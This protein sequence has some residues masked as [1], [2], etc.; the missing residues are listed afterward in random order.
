[1]NDEAKALP[2]RTIEI[3]G[4]EYTPVAARMKDFREKFP[5]EKGF[6]VITSI[7]KLNDNCVLMRCEIRDI[8]GLVLGTGHAMEFW[9]SSVLNQN[10]A[11]EVA[12]TSAIGRAL[13]ALGFH[14][15]E[16]AS[17]EEY[18][19]AIAEQKALLDKMAAEVKELIAAGNWAELCRIDREDSRW[20]E[21]WG[22]LG[23]KDRSAAKKCMEMRSKYRDDLNVM[24]NHGDADGFAQLCGELTREEAAEL[25]RVLTPEARTM[26]TEHMKEKD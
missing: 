8:T 18:D 19:R 17:Q 12:E 7:Q 2:T 16:Y 9:A 4:R 20:Q 25:Y 5:V 14:G 26:L 10:S 6:S 15:V 24:A 1:M 3:H 23:S 21:V 11:V 22:T 13:A